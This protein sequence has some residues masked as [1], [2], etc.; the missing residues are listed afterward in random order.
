MELR[1]FFIRDIYITVM[2][3]FIECITVIYIYYI[4]ESFFYKNKKSVIK[5]IYRKSNNQQ[6]QIYLNYCKWSTRRP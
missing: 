1:S 4:F 3:E 6:K 2:I 5:N